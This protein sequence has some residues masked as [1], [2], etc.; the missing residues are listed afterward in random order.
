MEIL[1]GVGSVRRAITIITKGLYKII[2]MI[3]NSHWNK[4]KNQITLV[5]PPRDMIP[6]LILYRPFVYRKIP[7]V[8]AKLH[9]Q[10]HQKF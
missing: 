4:Y 5:K 2:H 1:I 8:A 7:G 3:P 9:V 10:K 6:L